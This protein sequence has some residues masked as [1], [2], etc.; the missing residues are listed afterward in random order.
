MGW[1][2][3]DKLLGTLS[4]FTSHASSRC[5][6]CREALGATARK[7]VIAL[8]VDKNKGGK[9]FDFNF[10]DSFHSELCKLEDFNF[11]DVFL[12][13]DRSRSSDTAEIKAS[14]FFA[15]IGDLCATVAF[16]KHDH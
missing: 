3:A 14:V 8:V 4:R 16:G 13:E 5:C 6:G 10:P 11:F 12:C 7:K 15:G 2:F 1:L 9:V